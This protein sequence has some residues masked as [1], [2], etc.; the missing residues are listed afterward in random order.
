MPAMICSSR[1]RAIEP[2]ALGD[3]VAIHPGHAD[4]D[5][6]D[7]RSLTFDERDRG[8]AIPGVHHVVLPGL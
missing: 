1:Q 6:R 7:V 4:V 5:E 8:L 3:L 2:D